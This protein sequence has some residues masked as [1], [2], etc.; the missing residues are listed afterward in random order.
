MSRDFRVGVGITDEVLRENIESTFTNYFN[1]VSLDRPM[2]CAIIDDAQ[3][4]DQC[5]GNLTVPFVYLLAGQQVDY[6][7]VESLIR[8]NVFRVAFLPSKKIF[9]DIPVEPTKTETN[10]STL[11]EILRFSSKVGSELKKNKGWFF[12]EP[13]FNEKISQEI[14]LTRIGN[15]GEN[16]KFQEN[17]KDIRGEPRL[18]SRIEAA[19]QALI[20]YYFL[21]AVD[22][23]FLENETT[24]FD[25]LDDLNIRAEVAFFYLEK[26]VNIK[27]ARSIDRSAERKLIRR[28]L[29]QAESLFKSVSDFY[30]VKGHKRISRFLPFQTTTYNRLWVANIGDLIEE[31]EVYLIK[32]VTRKEGVKVEYLIYK[33]L[34]E[35][36]KKGHEA[37]DYLKKMMSEGI[38]DPLGHLL[39][40][41]ELDDK[42][43]NSKFI[44]RELFYYA[45]LPIIQTPKLF[46]EVE[47]SLHLN[48]FLITEFIGKYPTN[49]N[50]LDERNSFSYFNLLP[51]LKG[52][53]EEFARQF[54]L[55]MEFERNKSIVFVQN[56]ELPQ[57]HL[58]KVRNFSEELAKNTQ[59]LMGYLTEG[60]LKNEDINYIKMA[61]S[62]IETG[63]KDD[64]KVVVRDAAY[65]NF[66][67]YDG[68]SENFDEL[69]GLLQELF[70]K[71]NLET[72]QRGVREI[73]YDI[74]FDKYTLTHHFE[75]KKHNFYGRVNLDSVDTLVTDYHYL[76][77]QG[78]ASLLKEIRDGISGKEKI[79]IFRQTKNYLKRLENGQMELNE[80]GKKELDN[81][82]ISNK[83]VPY[84]SIEDCFDDYNWMGLFRNARH[85]EAE[86]RFGIFEGNKE[87][88]EYI[89][90]LLNY[91][92]FIDEALEGLIAYRKKRL[93]GR[94]RKE[95]SL[96]EENLNLRKELDKID[97]M[98]K[99]KQ[100]YTK[101]LY[102]RNVYKIL[103]TKV[104]NLMQ[105]EN[106]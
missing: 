42:V 66:L 70:I 56:M 37:R 43:P 64:T 45:N 86:I 63:L 4:L 72:F 58:N 92:R 16:E 25:F 67:I 46:P 91:F 104:Q 32:E 41:H 96:E 51:K 49:A 95:L 34:F 100:E 73:K 82:L 76:L 19:Y 9:T 106:S 5:R 78:Y 2:D 11:E 85:F 39:A 13:D 87:D 61:A 84:G 6:K 10:L 20:S 29:G 62:V 47:T 105:N 81:F 77:C 60:E 53:D 31:P 83:L 102:L 18:I 79:D 26:A 88:P 44:L 28:Y 54:K 90:G 15:Y 94:P 12:D 97:S 33:K 89:S 103:G 52:Y 8:E 36:G 23:N 35:E 24:V 101:L 3:F 30:T 22:P 50:D 99:N 68:K 38:E 48:H 75:S 14:Y 17:F 80:E 74:D 55:F 40:N 57:E 7:T 59:T 1:F 71:E 98:E 93:G 27:R 69:L 65:K 21:S